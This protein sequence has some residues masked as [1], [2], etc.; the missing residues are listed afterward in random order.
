MS[1]ADKTETKD[2]LQT[3]LKALS[4]RPAH[5][6]EKVLV[7]LLDVSKNNWANIYHDALEDLRRGDLDPETLKKTR[8]RYNEAFE[9]HHEV[10]RLRFALTK[11]K[12]TF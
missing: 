12:R 1:T 7:H 8:A 4:K 5:E 10:A 9:N 2:L 6:I 11:E 3:F